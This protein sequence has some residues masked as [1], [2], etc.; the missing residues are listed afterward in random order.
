MAKRLIVC[1]DG[2]WNFADQP[3]K[4][5]VT[6]VALSVRPQ[7][8]DVT[9]RVYYHSGVGTSRRER[10]RGG[11]FG[12]G[13]SRNVVDAYRFLVDNYEP[14]DQL[15]FFGFS[16][17]AFTARSLAG[18]VRNS[19]ILRG[20]YRDRVGDAWTLY[21]SRTEE[22]T[23]TASRLFRRSYAHETGIRFIGVWDTVGA[24][25]IPMPASRRLAAGVDLFNRRWAFHDTTLSSWVQSAF[26]ALAVD[27]QRSPFPPTLWRRQAVTDSEEALRRRGGKAQELKQ[28]WF[29]GVHCDIGGGYEDPAL[30]DIPLLWMVGEAKR[31]GLKFE[32]AAFT[33]S[34][35]GAAPSGDSTD[36]RVQPDVMGERHDSRTGLYRWVAPVPRPIGEAVGG[37]E[38]VSDTVLRRHD[39]DPGYQPK[40]LADYLK[41]SDPQ[42]EN[43]R[44]RIPGGE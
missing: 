31:C 8:G 25:G 12:V 16:R 14:G 24:L 17:G 34:E 18:L 39:A 13:L 43:V 21:R 30:S 42:V 11:A 23:S 28:V 41:D 38:R 10:L 1:C 27:E 3:S 35:P 32:D 36:I 5:N 26:H 44:P 19:G 40:N 15:Y 29:T 9:Q 7:D 4:T 33:R 20:E 2:T 22:P 37:H 6:K